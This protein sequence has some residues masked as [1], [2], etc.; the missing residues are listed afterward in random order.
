MGFNKNTGGCFLRIWR[1]IN[2]GPVMCWS[3]GPVRPGAPRPGS[4]P[5]KGSRSSF[6]N[7][8]RSIGL[9]VRCAEYVPLPVSRYLDLKASGILAQPVRSMQTYV[10]E[11]LIDEMTAPGLMIHRHRLDQHLTELAVEAG[12]GLKTGFQAY[13]VNDGQVMVR[14]DKGRVKISCQI[15][16]GADGPSSQVSRWMINP[17]QDYLIAAQFRVP[18]THSLDQTRVYFRPYL[19]GGYGWLFPKGEMANLGVGID[20]SRQ[21]GI[22]FSPQQ[23]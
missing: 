23:I 13:T 14:G 1:I 16:I 2:N 18:L 5:K 11:K 15:I 20:P 4:P 12:A 7:G 19:F 9:P 10:E 21:G 22:A 17:A 6:W 8:G 3:S